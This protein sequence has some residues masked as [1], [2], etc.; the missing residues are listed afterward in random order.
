MAITYNLDSIISKYIHRP[1]IILK[2][3]ETL[4]PLYA[5]IS[6][7]EGETRID[8]DGIKRP[9]WIHAAESTFNSPTNVRR[10]FIGDKKVFIQYYQPPIMSGKPGKYWAEYSLTEKDRLDTIMKSVMEYNTKLNEAISMNAKPPEVVKVTKTGLGALSNNWKMSNLE[11][12]Y[13]TPSILVSEDILNKIPKSDEVLKV[14]MASPVGKALSSNVPQLIFEQANGGAIKNIR[15]RFPRLRTVGFLTNIEQALEIP[16]S[17]NFRDGA[18]QSLKEET[19]HWW[20]IA[21]RNNSISVCSMCVSQIPFEDNNADIQTFI[22]RPGIY[23]YDAQVLDAYAK[24]YKERILDIARANRDKSLGK[25][26]QNKEEPVATEKSEYEKYL[27]SMIEK[28]G[29]AVVKSAL[30]LVNSGPHRSE[31][32]EELQK[33]TKEGK[34]KYQALLG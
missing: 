11:E 4:P 19:I 7:A 15:T 12:V 3:G 26:T 5:R 31:V 9:E 6:G 20:E 32:K 16:G 34:A 1:L 28:H 25:A 30:I 27:D 14:L 18:P 33:M 24:K 22:T 21:A 23:K 29:T 13:I 17:R 8:A 2:G 10:L